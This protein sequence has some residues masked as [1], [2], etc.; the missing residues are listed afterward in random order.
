MK[1]SIV[2]ANKNEPL[3][4]QVKDILISRIE[5]RQWTPG[6]IIP[7]E[8][9]L[10]DEFNVS[11]TT[12]R[13]AISILVNSG[14]LE[15]KQGKGTIV[16]AQQLT[17]SL[18]RLRGFAEEVMEKGLIPHSK[19][20]RIEFSDKLFHEKAM[21]N[22]PEGEKVLV[23]ERVRLA[24]EIPI[25]IERSC[26]PEKIGHILKEHDLDKAKYY[27]ILEKNNIF[28]MQANEKIIAINAT[29]QEA[30]LLGIR[31]GE[32]LLEMSRLSFGIDNRPMEYTRTKYRSDQY[33][34][35]IELKR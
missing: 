1:N 30:D 6:T 19:L 34:Y 17:G 11:R 16:K 31:A 29:I 25:A 32:A 4:H 9:E 18:G 33:S 8:Q 35:S 3:Y 14:L 5:N 28:L 20:L 13:E 24:N 26:W 15:R 2:D 22:I 10:M 7:T 23:I 12:I 21:L 27:E